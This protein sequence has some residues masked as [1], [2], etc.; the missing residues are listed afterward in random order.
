MMPHMV[1]RCRDTISISALNP[2]K[3]T[4]IEFDATESGVYSYYC[5]EFC[6]ALHLEMVGYFL[7]EP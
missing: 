3:T 7:V 2:A 6:S 4:T 1:S 5:S